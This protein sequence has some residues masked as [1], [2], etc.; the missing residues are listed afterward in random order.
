MSKSVPIWHLSCAYLPMLL[1]TTMFTV[2]YAGESKDS[3]LIY[4]NGKEYKTNFHHAHL[5]GELSVPG[6]S[7]ILVF[8]GRPNGPCARPD[9]D[10]ETTVYFQSTSNDPVISGRGLAYPGDYYASESGKLVA[11]VRMFIGRCLDAREGVA[12]FTQNLEE[13]PPQRNSLLASQV[14]FEFVDSTQSLESEW[15]KQQPDIS[16]ARAA[17]ANHLCKEIGPLRKIDRPAAEYMGP[18]ITY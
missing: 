13:S 2:S 8:S 16:V 18:K 10:P 14:T 7:P 9:C 11:R 15:P 5:L 17:V 3:T 1:A 12:W 4:D 6:N